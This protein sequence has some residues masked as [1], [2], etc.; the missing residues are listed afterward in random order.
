M[1]PT[2]NRPNYRALSLNLA[3]DIGAVLLMNGLIFGLG[4]GMNET[5]IRKV[6]FDPPGYVVGSVWILLFGLMATARWLVGAKPDAGAAQ[7]WVTGLLIFCLC[8]PLYSLALNSATGG[9]IGNVATVALAAFT[10]VRV[11]PVSRPAAFLIAPVILWVSFATF[12][13]LA[14]LGWI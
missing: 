9:L 6:S 7:K 3:A 10:V 4:W 14:E 5:Q 11:Y 1:N 2:V 12:I 13:T 8:Y